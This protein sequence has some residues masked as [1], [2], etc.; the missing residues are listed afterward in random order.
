MFN[1]DN[2]RWCISPSKHLGKCILAV[3]A[4]TPEESFSIEDF[5]RGQLENVATVP[6]GDDNVYPCDA[7]LRIYDTNTVSK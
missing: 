7:P 2:D 4:E 3:R 1:H 6:N 5:E